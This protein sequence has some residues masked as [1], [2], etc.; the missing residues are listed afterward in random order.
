MWMT[1]TSSGSRRE[2]PN[3]EPAA[4]EG[5]ATCVTWPAL[6]A[7]RGAENQPGQAPPVLSEPLSPAPGPAPRLC[8]GRHLVPLLLQLHHLALQGVHLLL[9]DLTVHLSFLELE[10]GLLLLFPVLDRGGRSHEAQ[11]LRGWG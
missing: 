6:V 11:W 9:V 4:I 3:P 2:T 1:E 7:P 8:W 10:Q 5:G